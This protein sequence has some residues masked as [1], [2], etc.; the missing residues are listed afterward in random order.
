MRRQKEELDSSTKKEIEQ[1]KNTLK[2]QEQ[3][4]QN[5]VR[6]ITENNMRI[7]NIEKERDEIKGDLTGKQFII[8]FHLSRTDSRPWKGQINKVIPLHKTY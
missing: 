8:L 4:V 1:L 3:E 2:Q 7:Q 6:M 5:R